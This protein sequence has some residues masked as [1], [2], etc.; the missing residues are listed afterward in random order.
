MAE[1]G[2]LGSEALPPAVHPTQAGKDGAKFTVINNAGAIK[3][4]ELTK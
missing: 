2:R 1:A 3:L 4:A